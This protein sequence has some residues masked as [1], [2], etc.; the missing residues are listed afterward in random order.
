[1]L[2]GLK[3]AA[4]PA[5]GNVERMQSRVLA[6][7]GRDDLL[8]AEVDVIEVVGHAEEIVQVE[9]RR[10]P[11]LAARRVDEPHR[12]AGGGE[13]DAVAARADGALRV[14][15]VVDDLARGAGEHVLDQRPRKAQPAMRV[16]VRALRG[17][18]VARISSVTALK[19]MLASIGEA[20]CR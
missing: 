5:V 16:E 15:P 17:R 19:P 10:G 1:M 9:Q 4:A 11:V 7:V 13:V 3:V 8:A 20:R 18:D 12:L 2:N 6:D 14:A